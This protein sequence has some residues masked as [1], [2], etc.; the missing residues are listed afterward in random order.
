MKNSEL[1]KFPRRRV[2]R[3]VFINDQ[4][5]Y[6]SPLAQNNWCIRAATESQ[7]SRAALPDLR[8]GQFPRRP[9]LR[10]GPTR[11]A[12]A[13][14]LPLPLACEERRGAADY[15]G[16]RS[17]AQLHRLRRK[18]RIFR[19]SALCRDGPPRP[20]GGVRQLPLYT[21]SNPWHTQIGLSPRAQHV[22]EIEGK[23]RCLDQVVSGISFAGQWN[24][25]VDVFVNPG[26]C[27]AR[28]RE[29]KMWCT[30]HHESE[31]VCGKHLTFHA[32]QWCNPCDDEGPYLSRDGVC[33]ETPTPAS[34]PASTLIPGVSHAPSLTA[35]KF[36]HGKT[37]E[38]LTYHASQWWN[39]CDEEGP[40]SSRGGVCYETLMPSLVLTS[41]PTPA[42]TPAPTLNPTPNLAPTSAPTQSKTTAEGGESLCD[43]DQTHLA[44]SSLNSGTFS[45]L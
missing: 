6:W 25:C 12:A 44:L 42:S 37:G 32:S 40:C 36:A 34:T 45:P 9:P 11:S 1:L 8:S 33:F 43:R 35:A 16:R 31:T 29:G 17:C 28:E 20:S 10:R 15:C 22:C 24:P 23:Q 3:T 4:N 14:P 26:G 21:H 18:R 19:W 38:L 7:F 13:S 30:E 2:D 41:P 39:P 27:R 5:C